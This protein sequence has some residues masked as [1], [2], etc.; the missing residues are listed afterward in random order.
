MLYWLINWHARCLLPSI[1]LKCC[2]W[3]F[4][5]HHDI[6]W[7]LVCTLYN[8]WNC[9]MLWKYFYEN[10]LISIWIYLNIQTYYYSKFLCSI[11]H[12]PSTIFRGQL[13]RLCELQFGESYR[14]SDCNMDTW[15][16]C[17]W[18]PR[19]SDVHFISLFFL[20]YKPHNYTNLRYTKI[21]G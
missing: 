6:T 12:I 16:F 19:I 17:V 8:L 15:C 4:R 2:F 1:K 5:S 20:S 3:L 9:K 18:A 21:A 13:I 14:L 10:I 7:V 11:L